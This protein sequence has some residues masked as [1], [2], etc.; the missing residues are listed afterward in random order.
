MNQLNEEKIFSKIN[1][2]IEES[3][4]AEQKR[5]TKRLIKEAL[6]KTTKK[7]ISK[8]FDFWFFKLFY[9]TFYLGSEKRSN[10]RKFSMNTIYESL[11]VSFSSVIVI[12]FSIAVVTAIFLALY[13]IKSLIGIDLF[14]GHLLK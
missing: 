3:M 6:P 7:I 2:L 11:V 4:S 13:Y 5:E 8:N 14:D 1:P 10:N 9:I 12:S